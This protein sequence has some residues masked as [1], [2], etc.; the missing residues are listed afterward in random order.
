MLV[1]AIFASD[2]FEQY[3]KGPDAKMTLDGFS[4]WIAAP[5]ALMLIA[6]VLSHSVRTQ[7]VVLA[8]SG[9]WAVAG[10]LLYWDAMFL[11][12]D[13]QGGLVFL[14]IPLYQ[15]VAVAIT[16]GGVTFA[17]ARVHFAAN[18]TIESDARGNSARSSLWALA[19]Y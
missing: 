19:G 18:S 14:F 10:V 12:V 11:H 17:R 7:V 6:V 15:L 5:F 1:V 13:A 3:A 8:L 2:G 4:V 16:L 9:M